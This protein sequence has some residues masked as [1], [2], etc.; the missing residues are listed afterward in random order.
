MSTTFSMPDKSNIQGLI[1]R[2]YTHPFSCH[3]LFSFLGGSKTA[4]T[5]TFFNQLYDKVQS[6]ADWG[7]Q[8]PVSMLNIGLTFNGIQQLGIVAQAELAN[9]PDAFKLGPWSPGSQASLTDVYDPKS[10]PSLWWNGQGD[11]VNANL[12][13]VI[14]IYGLT[15][16]DLDTL[17]NFVTASAAGNGLLEIL[18]LA[19]TN[20]GGRLYQTIVEND[21]AKIHFG[22]TDGISEPALGI[23]GQS[24][25]VKPEDY[26]NFLI[27]YSNS[28]ISQPGPFNEYSDGVFAKDGCYNAFRI[29]Y[30]DVAC[31]NEFLKEQ[32]ATWA[33]TLSFLGLSD[34]ELQEWFAAKICGRWRNGS[35]L[36]LNPG[37][38]GIFIDTPAHTEAF[39]YVE[40]DNTTL[41]TTD[42]K[43]DV[44]S[45]GLCPFSAHTRVANSRNQNLTPSEGTSGPPRIIRRGMPYGAT[46]QQTKDDGIDRGLIGLFL[47]GSLTGQF[48]FLFGWMNYNNF[49]SSPIFS[50][51][52]P[53]QDALLGNRQL[54]NYQSSFPGVV[55]S[56][57]IPVAGVASGSI[58]IPALPQWLTTRGTSYCL[59]PGLAS[60][61][62]IAGRS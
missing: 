5:R 18:P 49:S 54:A 44:L 17:V 30:Q 59:L 34:A 46:L 8:K 39:G 27:G 25:I 57:T 14:H 61:A 15:A 31:F 10:I 36:M 62:K 32:A 23:P 13:C 42:P 50:T 38:P 41:Q 48:E 26:S 43:N 55:T 21:P 51:G 45:G 40:M 4:D 11:S 33:G 60:L 12:H 56:F 52:K 3:L 35:A 37:K 16:N 19:P 6:A 29:I 53:P 20:A 9:F 22:Y 1:L 28:S 24:G 2:G 47:C 58:T 7:T